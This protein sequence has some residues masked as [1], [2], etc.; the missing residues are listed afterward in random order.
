MIGTLKTVLWTL[1]KC[2]EVSLKWQNSFANLVPGAQKAGSSLAALCMSFFSYEAFVPI[3]DF[4]S[5]L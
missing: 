3:L 2:C 1:Q 4:K 5:N